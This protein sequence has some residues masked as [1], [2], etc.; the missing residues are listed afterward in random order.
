VEKEEGF[1]EIHD[2]KTTKKL[3]EQKE[4][5]S[6]RQLALYQIGIQSQWKGIK[7]IQLVW[8][9]LHFDKELRSERNPNELERLKKETIELIEEIEK[10]KQKDDFPTK[11]SALCEWCDFSYLCP[12]RRHLEETAELSVNEFLNLP[13]VQLVNKYVEISEEIRE[14]RN[15]LEELKEALFSFVEKNNILVVRGSDNK[16]KIKFENG[17]PT[18]EKEPE[19]KLELEKIIKNAGK[20]EEVSFLNSKALLKI[21]GE[22]K[23]EE[24]LMQKLRPFIIPQAEKRIYLSRLKGEETL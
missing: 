9:F 7:N 2:Y 14:K 17:F 10:A 3:P 24:K 23:W 20:W 4:L 8:H 15:E 5:D 21:I 11:E 19:K 22:E 16:I 1:W 12:L 13:E 6:D 18:K